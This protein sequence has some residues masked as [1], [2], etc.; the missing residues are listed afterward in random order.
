MDGVEK[1]GVDDIVVEV[2]SRICTLVYPPGE[3]LS[4]SA[5][6]EEFGVSRTPI[7]QVLQRL[8]YEGLAEAHHGVGTLVTEIDF[9]T[10]ADVYALRM[11]LA[12]Q[13]G[14]QNPIQPAQ[15]AIRGLEAVRDRLGAM[16]DCPYDPKGFAECNLSYHEC[17]LTCVGSPALRETMRSA[18]L[19]SSRIWVHWIDASNWQTEVHT[20]AHEIGELVR[21]LRA[22]DVKAA[23]YLHRNH[24][25]MSLGR[26]RKGLFCS[27]S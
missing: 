9:E 21:V 1:N 14:S 2:R 20:F 26:M 4:E 23:G 18:F 5:L 12:E 22:G 6:A 15:E 13:V 3:V 17:W 24:I 27:E 11:H 10:L 25:S 19:R 16:L 8:E 7:R